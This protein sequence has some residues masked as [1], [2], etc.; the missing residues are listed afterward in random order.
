MGLESTFN[1]FT[2]PAFQISRLKKVHARAWKLYIY[3]SWNKSTLESESRFEGGGGGGGGGGGLS[4][5]VP[6]PIL[7]LSISL[8]LFFFIVFYAMR[9]RK[10]YAENMTSENE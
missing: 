6:P 10:H 2:A 8:S 7:S 9:I 1:S 4:V 3:R 5:S